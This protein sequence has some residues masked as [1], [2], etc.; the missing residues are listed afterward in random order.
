MDDLQRELAAQGFQAAG[1]TIEGSRRIA[2]AVAEAVEEAGDDVQAATILLAAAVRT[3]GA[4]H[5]WAAT[6]GWLQTA[7]NSVSACA[8]AE[9]TG[10]AL[11]H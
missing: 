9:Q 6:A 10:S 7:T 2:E 8:L 4:V 11:E 1:V 3:H 5:G